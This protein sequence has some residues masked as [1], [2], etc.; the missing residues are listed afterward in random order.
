MHKFDITVITCIFLS[1]FL[2][3]HEEVV[4]SKFQYTIMQIRKSR[5]DCFNRNNKAES[6]AFIA[7]SLVK[8][9]SHEEFVYYQERQ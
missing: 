9:L 2:F 7:F 5:N 6:F 4:T 3:G 1:V 8:L